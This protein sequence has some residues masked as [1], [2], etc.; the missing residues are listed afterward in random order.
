MAADPWVALVAV[1]LGLVFGSFVTAASHRLP[2]GVGLAAPPS[3]CPSCAARLGWRD[4]VPLLSWLAAGRRC[5]HCGTPVSPRYPAI[6]AATAAL[7]LLAWW[8]AA[9]PG[10]AL[11]LSGLVVGAMVMTVTDLECGII[12]DKVLLALAPLG[13]AW[14][15]I[16]DWRPLDMALGVVAGFLIGW[17]LRAGFRWWSGRHG[18]GLGDVKFLA[19]A[20]AWVGLSGIGAL[21]VLGGGAGALFGIAWRLAGGGAVFPFGPALAAGLLAVVLFPMLAG[22]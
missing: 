15:W 9:T 4:L 2:L 10:Q 12:P 16:A 19:V 6:E 3:R 5:R 11:V 7:F 14:R 1:T 21:L 8:Q 18:L 13:L 20:G 17:G 22:G